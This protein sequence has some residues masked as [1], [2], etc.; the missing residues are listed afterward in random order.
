M[1]QDLV[2]AFALL[3]DPRVRSVLWLGIGLALATLV[4]LFLG[5]EG[6]VT[7][8]SDTGYGWL[9]RTFQ[10]VGGIGTAVLAWFLFP[11]IV[12]AVSGIFLERVVDA[13]EE[14][15]YPALPP[16][17]ALPLAQSLLSALKLLGVS[18]LLNL[19]A[20]PAYFVPLLNVPVWLAVNG[21]LVGREYLEL[22]ASRRLAPAI[23]AR[24]RRDHRWLFWPAGAEIALL[25]AIPLLNLEAPVVGA[26]FMT[27]RYQ[28][29]C[30][31][32]TN[33]LRDLR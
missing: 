18:L 24:V 23:A 16:P 22:V 15:Y 33:A 29:H 17:R 20:L 25:L 14:R 4:L 26:A 13:T 9:D 3:R 21:Y 27:M 12:V 5:V 32:A 31:E 11:S 1:L 28:R 30:G 2:R 19:V 10:V 7:W 8:L 6:V